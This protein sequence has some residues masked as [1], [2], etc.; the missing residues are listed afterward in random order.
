[1]CNNI[2][3]NKHGR[4]FNS[5][6]YLE[7]I[8][9]L[10]SWFSNHNELFLG[11]SPLGL[12][13]SKGNNNIVSTMLNCSKIDV[14]ATFDTFWGNPLFTYLRCHA[15]KDD[16]II[17]DILRTLILKGVNPLEI[18][19]TNRGRGNAL[20]FLLQLRDRKMTKWTK[21]TIYG[22]PQTSSN[23]YNLKNHEQILME[24]AKLYLR[25]YIRGLLIRLHLKFLN[26][27]DAERDNY[28]RQMH[29][30]NRRRQSSVTVESGLSAGVEKSDYG[31]AEICER[32]KEWMN[33]VEEC[34]DIMEKAID[35][36]GDS[37][38]PV[39]AIRLLSLLP[40]L[41]ITP[42]K[43]EMKNLKITKF[44][45]GKLLPDFR[46]CKIEDQFS[47]E[48]QDDV[49]NEEKEEENLKWIRHFV[50]VYNNGVYVYPEMEKKNSKYIV[51]YKCL[52]QS[53]IA[54]ACPICRLVYFCSM[55]CN[56]AD[57]RKPDPY[58]RCSLVFWNLKQGQFFA[59]KKT[60][61]S[62]EKLI[63]KKPIEKKEKSDKK[64][65]SVSEHSVISVVPSM[66]Y[67]KEW[68][69][70]K[71]KQALSDDDFNWEKKKLRKSRDHKKFKSKRDKVKFRAAK[72]K[73]RG[74]SRMMKLSGPFSPQFRFGHASV[75]DEGS[76]F[77]FFGLM[78]RDRIFD[79]ISA[80]NNVEMAAKLLEKQSYLLEQ[81]RLETE[82]L[83]ETQD[84]VDTNCLGEIAPP[85]EYWEKD[86]EHGEG[87]KQHTS[88]NRFMA[89]LKMLEHRYEGFDL[90]KYLPYIVFVDGVMYYKFYGTKTKYKENYSYN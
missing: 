57:S 89:F 40:N 70:R 55:R 30:L 31:Y 74:K 76:E 35:N 72:R 32:T 10:L 11:L 61:G 81:K 44:L 51:C 53:A 21:W 25:K 2:N 86:D 85:E 82:R 49:E 75:S 83:K 78:E 65:K 42:K 14:N 79:K 50:K 15:L 63:N 62:T 90:E 54:Q 67:N 22:L 88:Q 8:C 77:D 34:K 37:C 20:N 66:D 80:K 28:L 27:M 18:S 12:A 46:N 87:K 6:R 4:N 5:F 52:K 60:P 17:L 29:Y 71:K 69:R 3:D 36:M 23:D 1:M 73:G 64:L 33:S 39:Q 19:Y 59:L 9:C 48:S 43:S 68:P 45:E 58:H 24:L 84:S 16:P 56:L 38:S 47:L 41:I 26:S 13:I 7:Q